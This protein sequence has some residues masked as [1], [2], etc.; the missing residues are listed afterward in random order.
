[1]W[2]L[3][4]DE[5]TPEEIRDIDPDGPLFTGNPLLAPEDPVDE[6]EID[7]VLYGED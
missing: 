2:W 6:T 7:D 5:P 4:A 1:M 3:I